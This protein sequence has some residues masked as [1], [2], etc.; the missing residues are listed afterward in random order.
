MGSK[1]GPNK[2][3]TDMRKMLAKHNKWSWWGPLPR[4]TSCLPIPDIFLEVTSHKLARH[5]PLTLPSAR[6]IGHSCFTEILHGHSGVTLMPS[7]LRSAN[8]SV[9]ST[10][11]TAWA[12][13]SD[14]HLTG[15][16]QAPVIKKKTC[17]LPIVVKCTRKKQSEK[18]RAVLICLHGYL[19]DSVWPELEH[20]R[21]YFYFTCK[22][23]PC[24]LSSKRP[25]YLKQVNGASNPMI[26]R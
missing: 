10:I 13:K 8:Q 6:M 22:P 5:Q 1:K 17:L 25:S 3:N 12:S 2:V 24:R 21:K 15:S 18:L 19:E 23:W 9:D 16:N 14:R 7:T 20:N 26:V 4:N 11:W